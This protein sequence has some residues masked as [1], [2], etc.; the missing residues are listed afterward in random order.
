MNPDVGGQGQHV[1]AVEAPVGHERHA[2]EVGQPVEPGGER[3]VGVGDDRPCATPSAPQRGHAV[4]HRAVE[5]PARAP[6]D[7]GARPLG[8]RPHLVVV[9]H[10]H[11][12]QRIG[13][14]QHDLGHVPGQVGPLARVE[15]AGQPDLGLVEG[16]DRHHHR[17]GDGHRGEAYRVRVTRRSAVTARPPGVASRR[18]PGPA[19]SA[20]VTVTPCPSGSPSSAPGRGAPRWRPWRRATRRPCCGPAAPSWPTRSPQDHRNSAYLAGFDLPEDLAATVRP[21]RGRQRGRRAGDGRAVARHAVDAAASW[22][23]TCGRGCR[24]SAWPRASRRAPTCA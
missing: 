5:A 19:S 21:R 15:R 14:Q 9:A 11:R 7:A 3:Q 2:R 6:H 16:L 12:G 23:P 24:S 8:P 1:G 20:A 10:D 17:G 4:G 22:R 13:R 18:P